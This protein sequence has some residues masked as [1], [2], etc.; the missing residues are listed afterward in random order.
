M[1]QKMIV[2]RVLQA[3]SLSLL[4][5]AAIAAPAIANPPVFTQQRSQR[6]SGDSIFR[7]YVSGPN[8]G[9]IRIDGP[10]QMPTDIQVCGIRWHQPGAWYWAEGEYSEGPALN[11]PN[12]G[13]NVNEL[14]FTGPYPGCGNDPYLFVTPATPSGWPPEGAI[15]LIVQADAEDV[16][17]L[18]SHGN[19]IPSNPIG[20]D[21][22]TPGVCDMFPDLCKDPQLVNP[23]N[24]P[25]V[26]PSPPQ[27]QPNL[28]IR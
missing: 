5:T 9:E 23:T 20:P 18:D 1:L 7:V 21:P 24:P 26:V 11:I 14:R 6:S 17:W 4:L 13:M 28:R 27:I 8:G 3:G 15:A 12:N 16:E 10:S 22:V 19:V 25:E 2:N